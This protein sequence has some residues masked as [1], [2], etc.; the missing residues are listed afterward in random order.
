M[1]L[2]TEEKE[3]RCCGGDRMVWAVYVKPLRDC[4]AYD[5][6]VLR[7]LGVKRGVKTKQSTVAGAMEV[8]DDEYAV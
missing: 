5:S 1:S 6:S 4:R 7:K 3:K 2:R 8:V